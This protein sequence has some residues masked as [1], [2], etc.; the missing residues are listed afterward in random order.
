[1]IFSSAT[2]LAS[3]ALSEAQILETLRLV[4]D[5]ELGCNIVDLGLIYGIRIAGSKVSVQMTLTTQGCPMHESIAG[6]VSRALLNQQGV[7][8]VEVEVVWDPPWQP[9]MMSD[10][11][12]ARLGVT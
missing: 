7:E 6:G 11:G 1:M 8:E 10:Y 3:P 12:R 4:I 5:P 2:P 9:S